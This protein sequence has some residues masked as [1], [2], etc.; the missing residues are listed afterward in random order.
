MNLWLI[1]E[2]LSFHYYLASNLQFS[3]QSTVVSVCDGSGKKPDIIIYNNPSALV[4]EEQPFSSVTILEFKRP[5]RDNY[6]DEENPIL[7][8][9]EYA[10]KLQS[11]KS[12]DRHGRPI[13]WR[14]GTPIYAYVLCDISTTLLAQ[15]QDR[16]EL[17]AMP[18]GQ[19]FVGYHSKFGV[20]IEIIP[21]DKLVADAEKRNASLFDQLNIPRTI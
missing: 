6:T 4:S 3:Q 1:D 20:W 19:G 12:L 2:K 9:Y 7:Q 10:Q 15:I 17:K 11:G 21:F 8:V 18:D 14:P 13:Q 16:D 5:L